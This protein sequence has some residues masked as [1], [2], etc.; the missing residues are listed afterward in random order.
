MNSEQPGPVSIS[1][2]SKPANAVEEW[3][4][5]SSIFIHSSTPPRS[6]FLEAVARIPKTRPEPRQPMPYAKPLDLKLLFAPAGAPTP[7]EPILPANLPTFEEVVAPPDYELKPYASI[8]DPILRTLLENTPRYMPNPN[9]VPPDWVFFGT[10][11]PK[12]KRRRRKRTQTAPSS[13][14][15]ETQPHYTPTPKTAVTPKSATQIPRTSYSELSKQFL[16]IFKPWCAG[17]TRNVNGTPTD[18][19]TISQ[20]LTSDTIKEAL[21]G[22]STIG[23]YSS[24]DTPFLAIDVD[25]HDPSIPYP[26]AT[27]SQK[28]IET[29]F[30]VTTLLNHAPSLVLKSPR[31]LHAYYLLDQLIHWKDLHN[32]TR[33][34][35]SSLPPIELK[36]TPRSTLRIPNLSDVLDPDT[37]KPI[38]PAT[39]DAFSFTSLPLHD[40]STLFGPD[41]RALDRTLR[42]SSDRKHASHSRAS[43][44]FTDRSPI[45]DLELI[46]QTLLPFVPRDTYETVFEIVYAC[47]KQNMSTDEIASYIATCAQSSPDYQG[48]LCEITEALLAR[49]EHITGYHSNIPRISLSHDSH[50]DTIAHITFIHPFAPQ[51]TKSLTRFLEHLFAWKDFHDAIFASPEALSSFNS[52]YPYYRVN[53]AA[54]YYPLPT[55]LLRKWHSRYF[56]ILTW[57]ISID[58]LTKSPH[59]YSPSAHICNYYSISFD[60]LTPP[61]Q[62][63]HTIP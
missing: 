43:S 32:L 39:L 35:L 63:C 38:S 31:G 33:H 3:G 23:F 13:F 16:S 36:P 24:Y 20:P 56:K 42:A 45:G 26:H 10:G 19:Q 14:V 52:L 53:R 11:R 29:Y 41:Y 8:D 46:K 57:L 18:W 21:S 44:A 40:P 12:S 51:R 50:D 17:Y 25:D 59:P 15:A 5:I 27:P 60:H 28:T 7:P 22:E 47:N 55:S 37:L 34:R 61:K 2:I 30:A 4:P 9:Y 54:S 6:E 1:K 58:V 48:D 49:I 62:T